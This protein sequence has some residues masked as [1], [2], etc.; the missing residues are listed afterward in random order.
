MIVTVYDDTDNNHNNSDALLIG[1]RIPFSSLG[2]VIPE[3]FAS[4]STILSPHRD[5]L[6]DTLLDVLFE[7]SV[8]VHHIVRW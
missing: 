6:S 1:I 4:S 8:Q 7:N 2:K 5:L 3:L